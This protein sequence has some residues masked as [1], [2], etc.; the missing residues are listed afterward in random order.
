MAICGELGVDSCV[1]LFKHF[2]S[3]EGLYF[4]LRAYLSSSKD[5]EMSSTFQRK[6]RTSWWSQSYQMHGISMTVTIMHQCLISPII[7]IPTTWSSTLMA[8]SK[9]SI[10]RMLLPLW[11]N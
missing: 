10:H 7:M 1:K 3:D 2:K 9:R 6:P 11:A 8:M 4:F 5:P